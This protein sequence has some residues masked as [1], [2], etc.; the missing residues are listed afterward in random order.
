MDWK[1]QGNAHK[2]GMAGPAGGRIA[3]IARPLAAN[4]NNAYLEP[5]DLAALRRVIQGT[6]ANM[7]AENLS[8]RLQM[9]L[10][11]DRIYAGLIEDFMQLTLRQGTRASSLIGF[12]DHVLPSTLPDYAKV[13]F[14]EAVVRRFGIEWTNDKCD[15]IDIAIGTARLQELLNALSQRLRNNKGD[16]M[17][18]FAVVLTPAGEQHTLMTHLLG[19]LFDSLG[20]GRQVLE[21]NQ[22]KGPAF[23]NSV[24][25]A[26]VACIGWSNIRL[27]CEMKELVLDIR[28]HA[29]TPNLPLI[30]GGPAALNSIDF[31]VGLGIDCI[32][33]TVYSAAKIC[34]SYRDLSRISQLAQNAGRT[35]LIKANGIDWLSQ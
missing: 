29:S 34:E 26:D 18:P 24:G 22:M 31:L 12:L 10:E 19:L 16:P 20:W 7:T 8:L 17:A 27:A 30:V 11:N 32:C 1:L 4:G 21:P 9:G 28:R 5:N 14:I 35:A 23:S 3:A 13:L 33:D 15:L 6:V 25:L 2:T